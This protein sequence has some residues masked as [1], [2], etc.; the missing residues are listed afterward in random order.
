MSVPEA[1][2][3]SVWGIGTSGKM[4]QPTGIAQPNWEDGSLN[5]ASFGIRVITIAAEPTSETC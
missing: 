3:T 4:L 1:R 2:I 5:L